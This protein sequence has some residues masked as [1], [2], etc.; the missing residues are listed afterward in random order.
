[1][2]ENEEKAGVGEGAWQRRDWDVGVAEIA[3]GA[4]SS[5]AVSALDEEDDD[6][7]E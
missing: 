1:M 6:E 7:E 2:D 5:I 4:W 3:V